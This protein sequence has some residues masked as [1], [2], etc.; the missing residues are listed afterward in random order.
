MT[1]CHFLSARKKI[2]YTFDFGVALPANL[3]L[4]YVKFLFTKDP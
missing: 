3:D 1:I 2:Y 4:E